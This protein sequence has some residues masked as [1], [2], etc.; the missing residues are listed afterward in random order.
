MKYK[1]KMMSIAV[2]VKR[3]HKKVSIILVFLVVAFRDDVATGM[4]KLPAMEGHLEI[5]TNCHR[6]CHA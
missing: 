2:F 1:I 6:A 3:A 5:M 4:R